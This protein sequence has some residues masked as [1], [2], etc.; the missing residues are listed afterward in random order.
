MAADSTDD[1]VILRRI[2]F[3]SCSN[4]R[5]GPLQP[6]FERLRNESFQLWVWTGD[7]VYTKGSNLPALELAYEQ[8]KKEGS[9]DK[10]AAS[11]GRVIGTW[12]DHD[13]G[14]FQSNK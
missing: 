4:Q 10:F 3:G 8:L 11:V 14:E 5:K 6:V 1:S 7:A 2:G 12:D 13:L 9:Y